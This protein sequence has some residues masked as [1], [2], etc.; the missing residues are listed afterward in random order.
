MK[1]WH[2][3]SAFSTMVVLS[4]CSSFPSSELTQSQRQVRVWG[5]LAQPADATQTVIIG[6]DTRYVN[7]A[8]GE[9]VKF[10]VGDKAFAWSF[11]PQGGYYFDLNRIAPAG[12]LDHQVMVSVAVS[13]RYLPNP[14]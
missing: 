13:E 14:L 6:R 12:M 5:D 7:L 9:T 3:L 1:N 8:P 4:A 11:A 10:V 2:L